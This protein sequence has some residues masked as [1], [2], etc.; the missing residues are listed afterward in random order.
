MAPTR[1][2]VI[3]A[4]AAA[5]AYLCAQSSTPRPF[6]IAVPRETLNRILRR[7]RETRFPEPIG[8]TGGWQYG[9]S[10][11]YLKDLTAYWTTQF[12]WRKSEAKL[13]R[14]PQFTARV[15]DFDIHF[16]HVRGRGPRPMPLVLTH[17][18]PGSV[19]E[20]MDVTGPLADPAGHSGNAD[21]SFDLVI[22]SLPGF[23]YSSKPVGKPVGPATIARLWHKLMTQVLGYQRFGAQGGDWG[24]AITTQLAAQFP[25]SLIGIHLNSGGA[26]PAPEAEQTEEERAY[27]RAAA[28]YARNEFD[29]FY[30]QTRKPQTVGFALADNPLGTAAWIVEKLKVWSDSGDNLD[31]TLTKD[32]VLTNVMWYLVTQTESS[33]VWIYRGNADDPAAPRG[34]ITVPTGFAAFPKEMVN[35]AAPRVML[36]RDYNLVHYTKMPRG[37]HFAAF[38]QPQLFVDD[39]R[40]FF[41][42][43]R[44]S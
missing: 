35:L 9:V 18:W 24:S 2:T 7:V 14:Y 37:G 1:R 4:L 6:K 19:A 12:D 28:V 33:A 25:N 8:G 11:G 17:G 39:V 43:V 38:E 15:D 20:F 34:K 30:E 44:A 13:N 41:R 31:Q 10:Y 26:R 21:D 36:E 42:K 29:Y 22:P 40:A 32:Q 3:A 16:Y 23:G 5:P 27:L